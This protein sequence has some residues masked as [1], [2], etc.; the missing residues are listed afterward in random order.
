MAQWAYGYFFMCFCKSPPYEMKLCIENISILDSRE[1][2][3]FI[4]RYPPPTPE[5]SK[6]L[7]YWSSRY[8]DN[9]RRHY[10]ACTKC[11]VVSSMQSF[12]CP[13]TKNY[14]LV[15]GICVSCMK[16]MPFEDRF[17]FL[18]RKGY[19]T[20]DEYNDL[21]FRVSLDTFYVRRVPSYY[22]EQIIVQEKEN[23]TC[24]KSAQELDEGENE[25]ETLETEDVNDDEWMPVA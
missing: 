23:S 19:I 1:L 8:S 17:Q 4:K 13:W 20:K 5:A 25:N 15:W 24:L 12:R 10:S 18:L 14:A 9:K 2:A 11:L 3:L 16:Q 6:K 22:E 7:G 21:I